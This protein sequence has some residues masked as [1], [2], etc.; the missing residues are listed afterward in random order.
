MIT[1]FSILPRP[2]P[3]H[4]NSSQS[5][6]NPPTQQRSYAQVVRQN[7][8]KWLLYSTKKT[9]YRPPSKLKT[10]KEK[11]L[12]AKTKYGRGIGSNPPIGTG[13]C[14]NVFLQGTTKLHGIITAN[15]QDMCKKFCKKGKGPGRNTPRVLSKKPSCLVKQACTKQV[16]SM[17][18]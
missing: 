5:N 16:L 17:L 9:V 8:P 1:H 7:T 4:L 18:W 3:K 12:H 11:Q 14:G 13:E 10:D 6:S 2:D 15:A